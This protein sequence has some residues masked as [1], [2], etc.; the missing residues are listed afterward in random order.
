MLLILLI[1]MYDINRIK[2][3]GVIMMTGIKNI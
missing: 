3:T 2:L 1:I